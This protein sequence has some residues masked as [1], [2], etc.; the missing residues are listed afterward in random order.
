[1]IPQ[2]VPN[3]RVD[4][5]AAEMVCALAQRWGIAV[6]LADRLGRMAAMLPFDISIFSGARSRAEQQALEERGRPATPFATSTHAD[7][8][9]RG[10]P[11]EATGA[12]VWPTLAGIRESD[13]A[14]AQFGS[15]AVHAGLR[16]GGGSPV[17]DSGIPLDRWHVDLGPRRPP[18]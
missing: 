6:E 12:D 14:V 7:T 5:E 9:E 18:T 11:R 16:W 1:M 13:A 3:P 17:G 2:R 8:D 10:C 15:A 4:P